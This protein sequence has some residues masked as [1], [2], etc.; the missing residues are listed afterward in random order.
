MSAL[1]RQ[2]AKAEKEMNTN[3]VITPV[4][5][6]SGVKKSAQTVSGMFN[7]TTGVRATGTIAAYTDTGTGNKSGANQNGS[8][9]SVTYNFN[10]VNNSPK[11]LDR[12]EIYR[13]TNNQFAT[14]RNASSASLATGGAKKLIATGEYA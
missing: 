2:S 11:A 14:L 10:Q 5:D 4:V 1:R 7:A 6:L 3:P 9:S 12:S 8:N 13:Q